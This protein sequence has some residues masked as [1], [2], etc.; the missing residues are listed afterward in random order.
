MNNLSHG[1]AEFLLSEQGVALLQEAESLRVE[2][3]DTLAGLTRLRKAATADQAAAAWEMSD[4]RRRAGV[5]FGAISRDMYFTREA[6]EQASSARAA[7]YHAERFAQAG[8]TALADLCGGIGGDAIAFARRGL[9]VCA[10]ELDATRALFARRNAE[11]LGLADQISVAQTD[12]T[13]AQIDQKAAWF[14]PGRREA[15]RRIADPEDYL[16][17][18]SL[19]DELA[20]NGVCDVGV[21]L[22]PSIDHAVAK[23]YGAELEFVSDNGECKEALLWRG[24][25]KSGEPHRAV[26]LTESGAISLPG[27]PDEDSLG[28]VPARAKYL[29]EPDPAVIRAHLIGTLAGQ[30]GA[31][32]LHPQI[33][34]LL[35]D[36]L[37]ATPWATAYTVLEQFPYGRRR[38]Q[39]SLKSHGVGRV[40][41]KK[42]GFPHEPEEI[43]KQL[44]L[45]GET[46]M[47]VILARVAV[48]HLVFLCQSIAQA[49][50]VDL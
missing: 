39:E 40:I 50:E 16:P 18:L 45:K 29:Y 33:A 2:R 42:R 41:I 5:K 36:K 31:K 9:H 44:K 46:E 43:R 17:P 15:S 37:V 19:L 4:L 3:A 34:Y 10:Y 12:I 28:D 13:T 23:Q 47:I 21:K 27:T 6:L 38:L 26:K 20:R 48:G 14:D 30:L 22:S 49:G 11:V 35:G 8:V 24:K 7:A 32:P 25:L 1:L